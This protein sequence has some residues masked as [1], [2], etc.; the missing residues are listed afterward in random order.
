MSLAAMMRSSFTVWRRAATTGSKMVNSNV[1]VIKG[2]LQPVSAAANEVNRQAFARQFVI[3]VTHNSGV[4]IG[5]KLIDN[6]TG[7]KY[8]V[9]GAKDNNFGSQPYIELQVQ[10]EVKANE[11]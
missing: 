4:L 9:Q 5:D 1:G 8:N 6:A 10:R 3:Y 11:V 7:Y 2:M